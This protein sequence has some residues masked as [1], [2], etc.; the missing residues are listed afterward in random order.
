MSR[1]RI[2]SDKTVFEAEL[3]DTPTV[4]ALL[5]ALPFASSAQT[6]GAE[7]YFAAPVEAK[8][9]PDAQQVVEPGTVCYWVEGS[10]LALPFGPT[11]ASKQSEPRLATRCN[12]LGKLVG[13]PR[14][15]ADVRAG[16]RIK[17]EKA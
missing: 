6:W 4:S 7:V 1:I 17:V 2:S 14:W 9:E 11:P 16:D 10:S 13:D 12:I 15:L 5:A 8:L 3:R